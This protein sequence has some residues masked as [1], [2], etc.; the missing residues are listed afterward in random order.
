MHI[1]EGDLIEQRYFIEERLGQGGMGIVFRGHDRLLNVTVAIKVLFANTSDL[2]IKRF[3]I[4]ARALAQLNHPNILTVKDFGQTAD[5]QLFLVMDFIEGES[6]SRITE[7]RG[8]QPFLEVLP[9]FEQ[10]CRALRFAHSCNVLHRDVKPS[11]IML[12]TERSNNFVKLVDFGLAKQVDKDLDLTKTGSAMGS[13]PYM[14]PEAIH[15]IDSDARS[16]IYSLGCTLFELIAGVPPF[17]GDTHFH[18]MMAHLHKLPPA[19]SE[20]LEE[21]VDEEIED[22]VQKCLRKSPEERFQT[23]E[24]LVGE[25]E[26][27]KK[28]LVERSQSRH[29]SESKIYSSDNFLE[30]RTDSANRIVKGSG[31]VFLATI[32]VSLIV[33]IVAFWPSK[34]HAVKK[35]DDSL[36]QLSH[37]QTV[38]EKTKADM[39]EAGQLGRSGASLV[40]D[41][42]SS[43]QMCRL[44]GE[45][46]DA[47]FFKE[48]EPY[49]SMRSFRLENLSIS[50]TASNYI[51]H[52]PIKRLALVDMAVTEGQINDLSTLEHLKSLRFFSCGD[53]PPGSL[54]KFQRLNLESFDFEPGKNYDHFG[55]ALSK[56]KSLRT[57]TIRNGHV[58]RAD[59]DLLLKKLQISALNF[60]SCLIDDDAFENLKSARH[61][62]MFSC[63]NTKLTNRQF[64]QIADLPNLTIID[65]NR[66]NLTDTN[67]KMFHKCRGLRAFVVID[68]RIS[69][70]AIEL[71]VA[72][73]PG[74]KRES[75]ITRWKTTA[76]EPF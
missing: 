69:L 57:V 75:V 26:S 68:T 36:K 37:A 72:N 9:V 31:L 61:C 46:T 60:D 41:D 65:L 63:V 70:T 40:P 71:L 15:G 45:M 73:I 44:Y 12:A 22:F 33:L 30:K 29:D 7:E 35:T 56:L 58:R 52:L 5:G 76:D 2:V 25:L 11:N 34:N 32:S 59:M 66:T 23:M 16:D 3:H 8:P 53:L 67:L 47:E 39:D 20:I 24:E 6:L 27:L 62:Y 19:L 74:L 1:S 55:P 43:D 21:N 42:T 50:L 51:L 49:K 13:P 14:S 17:V 18:T 4:E 48:I 28:I 54:E 64:E 38:M 10:V